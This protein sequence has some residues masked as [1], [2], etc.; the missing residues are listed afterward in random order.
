MKKYK[1]KIEPEALADIQEITDWYNEVQAGLG[2]R[3]QNAVIK[4]ITLLNKDPQIYAIRYKEI[5][6]A[7]IK[8]FPYMTH[9]YINEKNNSVEVLAVISTDRNPKIW[10]EKTSKHQ[11]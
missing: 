2:K 6:C 5:R 10:K 3:F 1:V 7:V 11:L 9:F 8:K 4:Q